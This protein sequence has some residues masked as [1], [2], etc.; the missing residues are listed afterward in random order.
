MT[1]RMQTGRAWL[2]AVL[3]A[4]S[5]MVAAASFES[6]QTHFCE[7]CT[8]AER[9]AAH[10]RQHYMPALYCQS[11]QGSEAVPASADEVEEAARCWSEP[12]YKKVILANP[13]SRQLFA[14]TLR[15]ARKPGDGVRPVS[16]QLEIPAAW[17]S[18]Y[19]GVLKEYS[20]YRAALAAI[21]EALA[22]L[23]KANTPGAA[24][25][26]SG[27]HE[28]LIPDGFES[29]LA[30]SIRTTD[31]EACPAGTVLDAVQ[32]PV[33]RQLM[34]ATKRVGEPILTDRIRRVTTV[35]RT[36]F[37][38]SVAGAHSELS[39]EKRIQ[40]G[41]DHSIPTGVRIPF[42]TS[43]NG[44]ASIEDP[45]YLQIDFGFTWSLDLQALLQ[46]QRYNLAESRILGQ[47]GLLA[48]NSTI[49]VDN[50][51]ALD[52]LRRLAQSATFSH[53]LDPV[54]GVRFAAPDSD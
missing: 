47:D 18:A 22:S 40:A 15:W 33:G 27:S 20:Q 38:A 8:Y 49:E 6:A 37:G 30:P 43:E 48:R 42:F 53:I 12:R 36:H 35:K 29:K 17:Q 19:R 44:T 9:A 2:A 50:E 10:A 4:A 3:L 26:A 31:S 45:D 24:H 28:D 23:V 41:P 32:S 11:K 54:S 39:M 51:C 7:A 14:V 13:D 21:E 5:P 25:L 52:R 34:E 16:E 46:D 1:V